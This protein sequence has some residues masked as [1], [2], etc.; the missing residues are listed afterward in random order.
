MAGPK[1]PVEQVEGFPETFV[2]EMGHVEDD[3]QASHLGQQFTTALVKTA[4]GIG[5]VGIDSGPIMG[6]ADGAQPIIE[7]PF[8]M[9]Q[10]DQRIS[11]L[12]AEHVPNG[13]RG[14]PCVSNP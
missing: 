7:S 6:W 2:A 14:L 9:A 3:A 5:A 13:K 11:P 10:C 12:E 8:Q 1:R 4:V